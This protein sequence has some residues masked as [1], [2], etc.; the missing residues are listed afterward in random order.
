MRLGWVLPALG[1]SLTLT[2]WPVGGAPGDIVVEVPVFEGGEG[3]DFFLQCARDYTDARAERAKWGEP[4]VLID[5]YGDPRIADKVRVRVLEG[6]FPAVTNAGLNYW[7]LI[8]NGDVLPLDRYLDGPNWEDDSTWRDSFLPGSL[9]RYEYEGRTYGIPLLYS[10]FA[11]WYNRGMFEEHKWEVPRTWDELF[12]LCQAVKAADIPPIAFQGRY[13]GYAQSLIDSAY[14]HLAGRERFY[15]QQDIAEGSFDNPELVEAL[16]LVQELSVNYFQ[17]GSMGMSHTEAQQQF[18][19]GSVA[20]IP[21]G[22]WLK[23]EMIGK[24]PD[25]FRLGAF[26][27]PL[28]NSPNADPDAIYVAASYYFAMR[29]SPEREYGIDFLRFMTS[30]RQAGRFCR[31]RDILAAVK[32]SAEGN[33]TADMQDMLDIVSAAKR[34]YGTAPGEGHPEMEQYWS[35]HRFKVLT[36]AETPAKAAKALEAGAAAVR[37]L[38]ANPDEITVRHRWEPVLLLTILLAA[39]VYSL[40]TTSARAR[41][42]RLNTGGRVAET[43]PTMRRSAVLIFVGPAAL[44]YTVFVIIP[45]VRSF[46]WSVNRWDGLTD[47]Q[48]VGALNFKRLLFESDAFWV[49]LKNNL[50]IMVVIPVFVL[51][52]SLFFA[53]CISRGLRGSTFFRIVFFFPNILG[54]VAATL[55]WMHLYNPSGGPINEAIGWVGDGFVWLGNA[56]AWVGDPLCAAGKWLQG[57]RGF[58]WLSQDHLYWALIPMSVWGACGFN[59]VLFLAAMESIPEDLYEAAD[60]DGA[61]SWRQFVTITLPLIWEVLSIAI[62]FMVIGGMKAFEVIWLL[63]NQRPTTETHVIGTQMVQAM[64]TEFKVGEAT[65]VAVLLFLMVFFGTWATLRLMRRETVEY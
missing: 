65:A 32:G 41:Q 49:A 40:T 57:A 36:G 47:M 3:L 60:L 42:A 2:A 4:R 12:A 28:P 43:R 53:T 1:L 13:P 64:F 35:D 63:T 58:A 21:C 25:G 52:L 31:Q 6:S 48:Y 29:Q 7:A 46:V 56:L 17:A 11:I 8:R 54:G 18:F 30:R 5:L 15:E 61:S 10:A 26:N 38:E 19:N 44:V 51:P 14:Y 62:V 27:L 45:C 33:I 39:V 16:R 20:M 23:S 37:N 9:D 22:S 50:F 34:T 24:I 55:L 59:M